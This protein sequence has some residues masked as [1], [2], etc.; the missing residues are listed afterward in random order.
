MHKSGMMSVFT[1]I[2]KNGETNAINVCNAKVYG[3]MIVC[4]QVVK[5]AVKEFNIYDVKN[6]FKKIKDAGK[7]ETILQYIK[8]NGE[9]SAIDKCYKGNYGTQTI[10]KRV[11][12]YMMK[13]REIGDIPSSPV[14]NSP[15]TK[16]V[17]SGGEV[18]LIPKSG[19]YK[20]VFI[21]LSGLNGSPDNYAQ[22]F[23]KLGGPIPDSFKIILPC[24]PR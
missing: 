12:Y 11:V 1:Y 14:S 6:L 21:F 18:H 17:K 15:F 16:Q 5:R 22:K 9:N 8:A 4:K 2:A 13:E 7:W 24:A 10:C 20:Y 23:G 3:T 19:K